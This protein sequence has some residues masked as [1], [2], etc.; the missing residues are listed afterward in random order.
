MKRFI[1]RFL[2][3]AAT[4]FAANVSFGE[5]IE[6]SKAN[7]FI[8]YCG[9]SRTYSKYDTIILTKDI[10][11]SGDIDLNKNL[12]I[13]SGGDKTYSIIVNNS[14]QFEVRPG[15][16]LTLSN[17][18][19]DGRDYASRNEGLFYLHAS[20][21]STKIARLVLEKGA[22]IKNVTVTSST[23]ADY[24]VIHVQKGARLIMNDGATIINCHNKSY[25]GNGGAICCDSGNIIING[26]VITG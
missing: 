25:Y 10:T 11:L 22:T 24:A 16:T 8:K 5:S 19:F 4:A 1:V 17:V 12:T 13:T 14:R 23:R 20:S 2:A 15:Y 9:S 6:I 3:F 21:D 7:D 18:T 26:G